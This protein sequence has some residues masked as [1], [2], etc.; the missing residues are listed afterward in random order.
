MTF[1]DLNARLLEAKARK[2][3]DVRRILS[4]FAANGALPLEKK[5]VELCFCIL[6]ANSNLEQTKKAWERVGN[7][8][9]GMDEGALMGA[10]KENGVRFH[11]RAVYII[12][13]R[14]KMDALEQALRLRPDM[15]IREWLHDNIKGL[16][17]KESSHFLRNIGFSDFAIVDT[18]VAGVMRGY[19]L[20]RKAPKSLSSE[21]TYLALERILGRKAKEL[22]M[23]MAELDCYLFYLGSGKLPRK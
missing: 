12:E 14:G 1:L 16:G 9:L 3:A 5:F 11:N 22:G 15:R 6:V 18:H 21:K 19:G 13:A 17:W 2:G 8:F 23:S 10:L 4:G 7:G 20:V